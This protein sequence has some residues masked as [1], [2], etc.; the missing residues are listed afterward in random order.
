MNISASFILRPIATTLL[1]I[2]LIVMGLVAY[3]LLPIAGV[4][5]VDFPTIQVA[6]DLPGASAE[7]MALSVA[8]PLEKA[9]GLISGVTSLSSTSALG[10]TRITVE[11]DL[12]RNVDG[13][14]QDV[15]MAISSAAGLLP[16]NLPNP[17]TYEKVNPA[18]ALLMSIAVTSDDLPISTVDGYAETYLAPKI[19]RI[20]GVGL[21]DFHGE[22]KVAVRVQVDPTAVAALGLNLEDIRGVLSSA[23]VNAPKGIIDGPNRSVTLETSDQL[24]DASDFGVVVI[25]Y[26]NGAPVRVRDIG[27]AVDGV[28]DV[29]QAAWLGNKRVVIIDV[30][31]EPGY[32]INE[33]VQ[34]VKDALPGLRRTLPASVRLR[35]LGDRT[36]TIRGS[37]ASVQ[38]TMAISIGLVVLVVF[39]FL[40]HAT[41]TL[42]PSV[43]IPVS[44][45]CSCAAMYLFGYTIDNISL[46]ALTIAVG[47]IIDDA[48]VMV[49]NIIRHVEA[50]QQPLEAALAGSREIVFTILSMTLSLVAVFIPVLLMGGLVGRLFREFAVTISIAL[51]MSAVVSLTVTPMMC[52]WMLQPAE[53][54]KE[55]RLAVALET[56]FQRSLR[57]YDKGLRWA[58]RHP[59]VVIAIMAV[60]VATTVCFYLIIPKGF[61][62]QQ[63]NGLI[64]CTTEA[65]PDISYAAMVERQNAL[66]RVI[67]ADPDVGTV[68][69]WVGGDSGL[70]TGRIM[71]DLKPLAERSASATAVLARLRKAAT[72]V[73]GIALF[74]QPRQDV[75]IGAKISKTQYQYTLQDPDVAELF[76]WAPV[77]M[78][79]LAS[80]PELQDVTGDLQTAAPRMMLKLD[81]DTLGRL[82]ISP[83][84]VDD[85]LY[86]AFGQRQV[87]T[88]FTQSDQRRVVL[89]VEPRAQD[90]PDVL[91]RLYVRSNSSGKL[92]PLAALTAL[93]NSLAPLTINHQDGFPSVTLSF[94]LVPG[95]SLGQAVGA[96][97]QA[98]RSLAMP[99][100]MT[101]RFEGAAKV[102]TNS[103]ANQPYL[104]A[105]AILAVY[106]VL[107]I[108]YE[109]FVHPITILSTLPSAGAG[110]F[111]ALILLHYEFTLIALIGVI[112]LVGIVKKNAIMMVDFALDAE[113]RRQLAPAAA[114]YEAAR[115]RFR[116]IM[117]TTMAALLGGLPLAFGAGAGSEL[118]RPL[119]IT[120]VG[121]LVVS[122]LLT[123]YT[124]PVVYLY[125]SKLAALKPWRLRQPRQPRQPSAAPTP[126]AHKPAAAE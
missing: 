25:G 43:A 67:M 78:K 83:Q 62:P 93:Q 58:L 105:A 7:T 8:A 89:E 11:F 124:T 59:Q 56:A 24:S 111:A 82:G 110:A 47:F 31:K 96:I 64:V 13:A 46:M 36:Q 22:Q 112:L 81:R 74:G 87:A 99:A 94:N 50:G 65:A 12:G 102:F 86:D 35:V 34:L 42:I 3:A 23:T 107:G 120:I 66:A 57:F 45:L 98:E 117:M 26:H 92:V 40:R 106:I 119:G 20:P 115:M 73:H 6:A 85:V 39:L 48:I 10:R 71:I 53:R 51:F 103:L 18:D 54:L 52:G 15:Q 61:F 19:S 9:L 91:T 55:N 60:A 32:N 63:D 28:E 104:I 44:L 100:A 114:I 113:R 123:L 68:Y 97:E 122:Q 75:Q 30:H 4:P 37:V 116:P 70:N 29:R 72:K 49:E 121:G 109:S 16:R 76:H 33:T 38:Q 79:R 108:L 14:A 80:L 118:R 101:T 17:P 84:S 88:I 41:A 1:V 5:Q 27:R 90:D 126:T 95:V 21:V 2:G 125:L 77:V 69:S